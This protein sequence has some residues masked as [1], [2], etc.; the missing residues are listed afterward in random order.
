MD[1]ILVNIDE[2]SRILS[3]YKW[4]GVYENIWRGF[5]LAPDHRI[6]YNLLWSCDYSTMNCVIELVTFE[7]SKRRMEEDTNDDWD[8]PRVALRYSW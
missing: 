3:K 2:G 5:Y 4:N 8:Y 7:E 6:D 1:T